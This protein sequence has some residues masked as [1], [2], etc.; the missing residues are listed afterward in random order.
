MDQ[1]KITQLVEL[2]QRHGIKAIYVD[3]TAEAREIVLSKVRS[4]DAVGIG[5]SQT[6]AALNLNQALAEMGC[7]V[8]DHNRAP[9]REE[10]T[11]MRHEQLHCD[12]FLSSTNALTEK[13]QLVNV[14]GVGNRVAAMVFGP[15]K[16]VV[17]AG[18]NKIVP[19]LEAALERIRTVAAPKNAQRLNRKTPCGEVGR[20][21]DCSS[22]ERLCNVYTIIERRP[23]LTDL[24][25]IIVGQELGY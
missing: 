10:S 5:G 19:D 24:E 4:G 12:L 3:T 9:S 14:D 17:V 11:A 6:I 18:I 23:S 25:V 15:K 13:G 1:A 7:R 8:L 20:C 16:V 21:T 2:L 22:Q